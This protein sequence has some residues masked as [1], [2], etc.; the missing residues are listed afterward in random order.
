MKKTY[1]LEDLDCAAC[2]AKMQEAIIKLDGVEEAAVNFL[3]QKITIEAPDDRFDQ[4]MKQV[5]KTIKKV[6]PDCSIVL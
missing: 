6:E 3:A 1:R 2:A 4:I 5:Q